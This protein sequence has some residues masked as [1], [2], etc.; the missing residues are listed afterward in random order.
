MGAIPAEKPAWLQEILDGHQRTLDEC[1]QTNEAFLK[2]VD[3]TLSGFRDDVARV[4]RNQ[5]EIA[6]K[7]K[8]ATD[9]I[10]ELKTSVETQSTDIR[11]LDDRIDSTKEDLIDKID[12]LRAEFEEKLA[13]KAA[14]HPDRPVVP[15]SASVGDQSRIEHE[16]LSLLA[17]ARSMTNQFAM[18]RVTGVVGVS[19]VPKTYEQILSHYFSGITVSVV[20]SVG[21]SQVK[22]F[23]VPMESLP[24]FQL[25]LELYEPQIRADGWWMT[26]D[27]PPE[28]RTM[29]SNAFQF[30]KE[31]KSLHQEVRSAYLDVSHDSGYVSVDGIDFVPVFMVPRAKK[32][33]PQLITLMIRVIDFVRDL[34]WTDRI[35]ST[36]SIDDALVREWAE[37]VGSKLPR[38]VPELS[39]DV[40][41]SEVGNGG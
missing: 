2:K 37:V 36:V 7:V 38:P 40:F 39:G 16:F 19:F 3:N 29:R 4:E 27:L 1:K 18:G 8:Q 11:A 25:N 21:K 28:L 15:S 32:K 34:E 17:K 23:S 6:E 12:K 31:V 20:P 9:D 14:P 13:G 33:W 5:V 10:T 30:F 26:V 41:M 24:G 35:T 22:R